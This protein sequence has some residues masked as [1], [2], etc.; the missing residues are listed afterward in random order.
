MSTMGDKLK[1]FIGFDDEDRDDFDDYGYDDGYVEEPEP[2]RKPEKEDYSSSFAQLQRDSYR[3]R[4]TVKD[5]KDR[6]I[7]DFNQRVRLNLVINQPKEFEECSKIVDNLKRKKP[8]ILNLGS[9]ETDIAKRIFDFVSGATYA[10]EGKVQKVENNI[11]VF[12]PT[13]VDV[14]TNSEEYK[15]M[16]SSNLFK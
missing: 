2:E 3:Q 15:S 16:S 11:F 13:N 12:A 10:L 8:I 1:R 7:V 9:L 6:K 5:D 14:S 4:D